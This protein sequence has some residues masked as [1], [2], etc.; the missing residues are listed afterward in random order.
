MMPAGSDPPLPPLLPPPGQPPRSRFGAMP[1][2]AAGSAA[3]PVPVPA[4]TPAARR[5][6]RRSKGESGALTARM[7]A[8]T[9]AE[10]ATFAVLE[11][12]VGGRQALVTA[13]MAAELSHDQSVV[14]GML[15]DP[16][17]DSASLAK[18]C[19]Q[20]N[21]SFA[22]LM[23]IFQGAALAK[24]QMKAIARV[25]EKLPDVAAAVMEDAL[26]SLRVCP[27]CDGLAEMPGEPTPDD[28]NPPPVRCKTCRGKGQ[29]AF[30]PDTDVRKMALQIG[31]L[32]DK[33]NG[34]K[35]IVAQ[36]QIS[37]HEAGSQFFDS[38][39]GALD[40]TLYGEG[41]ARLRRPPTMPAMP[42]GGGEGD[43]EIIDGETGEPTE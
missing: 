3:S 42:A 39:M 21:V 28:P 27:L 2:P 10:E 20:G 16:L 29:V 4:P 37:G 17:N 7:R 14:V 40:S 26:P 31:G 15:A 5:L 30:K 8:V 25:A 43:G 33:G 19:A 23:K 22:Q 32:L 36:Q 35:I 24:G 1:A 11:R 38:L 6:P 13:L 34:S 9:P 41:R 12:E 18:V